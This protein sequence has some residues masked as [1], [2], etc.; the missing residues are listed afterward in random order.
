MARFKYEDKTERK[1]KDI[2]SGVWIQ[3]KD[4]Y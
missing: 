4:I 3:L 1:I 2:S